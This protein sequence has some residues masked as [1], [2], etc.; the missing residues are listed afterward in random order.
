[1]Q[2]FACNCIDCTEI[3][4]RAELLQTITGS[5]YDHAS[6]QQSQWDVIRHQKEHIHASSDH[7]HSRVPVISLSPR[8]Q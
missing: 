4:Y 2:M 6:F 5:S 3:H 8:S 1:M 7:T